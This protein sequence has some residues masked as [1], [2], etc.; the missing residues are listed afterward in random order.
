MI[1]T[2]QCQ[3]LHCLTVNV[4]ALTEKGLEVFS[5]CVEKASV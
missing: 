4:D 2:I 5:R 3:I 1:N